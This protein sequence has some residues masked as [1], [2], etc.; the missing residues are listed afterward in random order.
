L[1]NQIPKTPSGYESIFID[2]KEMRG[3]NEQQTKPEKGEMQ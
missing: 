1:G 2:K 3:L